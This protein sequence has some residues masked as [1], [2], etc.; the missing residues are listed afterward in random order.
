M[1]PTKLL[2]FMPLQKKSTCIILQD[3][4]G[5]EKSV[6]KVKGLSLSSAYADCLTEK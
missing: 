6:I 1:T 2:L 5:Q 4:N 3:N